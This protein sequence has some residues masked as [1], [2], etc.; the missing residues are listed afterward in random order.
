M[1]S[2]I[3]PVYNVSNYINECLLSISQQTYDDIECILIDDCGSDD[4]I[5]K[6][7]HFINQ[8]NGK[9]I[10]KIIHHPFNKGL[11]ASRNTGVKESSGDYILFVD[12]D[13]WISPHTCMKLVEGIMRDDRIGICSCSCWVCEEDGSKRPLSK[14][15]DFSICRYIRPD[16]YAEKMLL[17]KSQHT[18][19]GKLYKKDILLNVRFREGVNNEDILFCLDSYKYIEQ[20]KFY[21]LEIPDK[22][23]YYR[24]RQGS[25]CHAKGN[26]FIYEEF[27]NQKVV[28]DACRVSKPYIFE[29]YEKMFVQRSVLVLSYAVFKWCVFHDKYSSIIKLVRSI[30]NYKAKLILSQTDYKTFLLHK[31]LSPLMLLRWNLFNKQP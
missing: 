18:A 27:I 9:I 19:W 31:Y 21:T 14:D 1:I 30:P 4:S 15:F 25:I 13:D 26:R 7:E 2:I 20:K 12:S 3:V 17:R 16:D 6:A 23:F 5:I 8:Y 24:M 28:M 10:F 22:L 11:S 29:E